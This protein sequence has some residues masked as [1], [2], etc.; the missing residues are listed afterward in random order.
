MTISIIIPTYNEE[1]NIGKLI[2]HL[3]ANKD[4]SVVDLIVIDGGS[5]DNTLAIANSSGA[6]A[7]Q[8]PVKGRA[9]QMNY[10]CSIAKGDVFYFIHADCIPPKTFVQDIKQAIEK[11]FDLGRKRRTYK[12]GKR[13]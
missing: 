6:N 12:L 4:S 1:N 13:R 8:S 2:R 11:E 9:A 10:G 5:N 3:N 7:V